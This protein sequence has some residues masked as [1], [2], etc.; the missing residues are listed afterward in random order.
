MK[1]RCGAADGARKGGRDVQQQKTRGQKK[2]WTREQG[3]ELS[4][5][6]L[7]FVR[8]RKRLPDT[9]D[10]DFWKL[11]HDLFNGAFT[12]RQVQ[13][14]VRYLH[15]RFRARLS[16][17]VAAKTSLRVAERQIFEIWTFILQL[18]SP[19]SSSS[20]PSHCPSSP[21]SS[22]SGPSHCP[23][24]PPAA[25]QG[26]AQAGYGICLGEKGGARGGIEEVDSSCCI[27][28]PDDPKEVEEVEEE[29][30]AAEEMEEEEEEEEHG[31]TA[32]VDRD[33]AHDNHQAFQQAEAASPPN[34]KQEFEMLTCLTVAD[35]ASAVR[36]LAEIVARSHPV[37][38]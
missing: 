37:P 1:V 6:V 11:C 25:R 29:E 14:K 20:A 15:L 38:V 28:K 33:S 23:S 21:P 16:S 7:G 5:L 4:R 34:H 22:S 2:F 26:R 36:T 13:S 9:A 17:S 8:Q 10:R 3:V 31:W 30:Q 19:S 24:A 27:E 32:G 18:I 35:L 12:N